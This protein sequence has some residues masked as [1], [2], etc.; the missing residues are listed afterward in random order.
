MSP[1]RLILLMTAAASAPAVADV[2]QLRVEPIPIELIAPA[3]A[4][5]SASAAKGTAFI[6][7]CQE[8]PDK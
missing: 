6:H 3:A 1:I 5:E 4:G 8:V 2:A 7:V